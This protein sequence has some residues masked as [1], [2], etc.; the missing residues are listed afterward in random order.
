[1]VNLFDRDVYKRQLELLH[2]EQ[3]AL[4]EQLGIANLQ[5]FNGAEQLEEQLMQMNRQQSQLS[6]QIRQY[7]ERYQQASTRGAQL[8]QQ[9]AQL[10]ED[11]QVLQ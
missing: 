8:E 1:M 6:Q 11:T 2:Q 3:A 4:A 9:H 5:P 7:T 10:T